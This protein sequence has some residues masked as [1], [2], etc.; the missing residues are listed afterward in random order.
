MQLVVNVEQNQKKFVLMV[1]PEATRNAKEY[2]VS[3][4]FF[5]RVEG[6]FKVP[7]GAVVKSMQVRVFETGASQ[8]KLT[9]MVTVS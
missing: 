6:S 4:K 9:Q 5:Q 8:P 1:P 3:F 2:H 7:S